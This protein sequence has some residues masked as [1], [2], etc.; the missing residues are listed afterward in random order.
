MANKRYVCIDIEMSK[1]TAT[2]KRLIHGLTKETIQI[3]AV[4]LD[5]NFNCISKFQ[6]YVKPVFSH[7]TSDIE[8]LTS[9]HQSNLDKADDFITAFDKYCS[10]VGD[11]D[12]TTFCWDSIDYK[13][14]WNELYAKGKHRKDLFSYLENFVDLQKTFCD[15][16]HSK[17]RLSLDSAVEV[18]DEEFKG[19]QHDA[20]NDAYNTAVV[21]HKICSCNNDDINPIFEPLNVN[22]EEEEGSKE[23]EKEE[24]TTS[25]ASFLSPDLQK[26]FGYTSNV[27]DNS[28]SYSTQDE[29]SLEEEE[30]SF[31]E[32]IP[33]LS[34]VKA[35]I[36]SKYGIP[37]YSLYCFCQN[38]S[39]TTSMKVEA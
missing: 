32:E 14:L 37:K 6:T 3:G 27:E 34:G 21:L 16:L 1:M 17:Q 10:W 2:E 22:A 31:D 30:E 25:F 28:N 35:E 36:C 15:L 8:E 24:Y 13:Q 5:E 12:I 20:L 33:A 29:G 26:L 11:S 18:I 23:E 38:I 19:A 39:S 9:I 7:M 4:M